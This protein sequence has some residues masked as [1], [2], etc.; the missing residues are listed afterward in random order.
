[1][2]SGGLPIDLI[3]FGMVAA[4]LI[5][6][7]RSVLGRRS[8]FERPPQPAARPTAAA[9]VVPLIDGR[10][11]PVP[12]TNLLPDPAGPVGQALSRMRSVAGNFD[13]EHFLRG[14]EAAFRMIVDAFARGD[15]GALRP[16]LTDETFGAFEGVIATRESQ[17]QVQRTEIKAL[18]EISIVG[19]E[20]RGALASITVRFVSD[21]NNVTLDQSGDPIVGAEAVT[22]ITDV[23]T[24]ERDLN[25][26]D[27]N[28][29]LAS[30]RSA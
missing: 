1:M 20:L 17:N 15:R 21:Q 28:W 14:A 25:A 18:R 8:G 5:L 16:L 9:P 12:A 4:F 3:L 13:P 27:P 19:A 29:R 23:W 30:A 11:E 22:E 10:A 7:L 2:G 24:F 6:R 26:A